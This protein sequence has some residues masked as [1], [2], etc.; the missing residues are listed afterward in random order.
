VLSQPGHLIGLRVI[1]RGGSYN[2]GYKVPALHCTGEE[3]AQATI[4]A[5]ARRES[6][7]REAVL[8]EHLRVLLERMKRENEW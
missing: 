8:C 4:C 1:A 5:A 2:N 3:A 6:A 7:N